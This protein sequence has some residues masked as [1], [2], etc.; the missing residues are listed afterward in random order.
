L[1]K[2]LDVPQVSNG[3]TEDTTYTTS[4]TSVPPISPFKSLER[5]SAEK[6]DAPNA[7]PKRIGIKYHRKMDPGRSNSNV[8]LCNVKIRNWT[9]IEVSATHSHG[10]LRFRRSLTNI[11]I[12][13]LNL[14]SK[15][16]T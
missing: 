16:E 11:G 3:A 8:V 15:I 12:R 13:R 14:T 7:A 9:A 4:A 6:H 10:S 1:I 5:S 2:S